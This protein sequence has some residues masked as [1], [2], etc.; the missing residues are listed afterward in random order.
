MLRTNCMPSNMTYHVNTLLWKCK[1]CQLSFSP[2][3]QYPHTCDVMNICIIACQWLL[4]TMASSDSYSHKYVMHKLYALKH[5]ISRYTLLWKC[6]H[7]QLSF[8]PTKQYPLTCDVMN[9]CIIITIDMK[10]KKKENYH[11][12]V[13]QAPIY[14]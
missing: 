6:K 7:C 14:P 3:K 13:F 12:F 10:K 2:T 9:I 4:S 5:D 11:G 8:S 1:H